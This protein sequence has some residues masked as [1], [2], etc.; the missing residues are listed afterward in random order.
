MEQYKSVA[1]SLSGEI[2]VRN[3]GYTMVLFGATDIK[4]AVKI[5]LN[6]KAGKRHA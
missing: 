2:E 1:G 4:R 6:T 5:S 3:N